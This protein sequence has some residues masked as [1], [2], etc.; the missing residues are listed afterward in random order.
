MTAETTET[1]QFTGTK[2]RDLHRLHARTQRNR[3]TSRSDRAIRPPG[4]A[5]AGG[6]APAVMRI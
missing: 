1:G 3:E 5:T 2:D 6:L 4:A